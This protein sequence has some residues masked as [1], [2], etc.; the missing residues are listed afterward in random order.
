MDKKEFITFNN[1]FNRFIL[2]F[3]Q[4]KKNQHKISIDKSITL[5]EVHLI[6]VIGKNQ[7][8]NLVKL[9]ELLKV[10]RSAITQS[11]RRLIQ[12][13]LVVFDFA[14]NN[15]KNKYLR[16]SEK[17]IEVFKIHKEQQA[18][19]EES[20]FSVLN[21]YSEEELQTVVK[22]MDDIENIWGGLPW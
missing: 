16:L 17:G 21:N 12:K 6:V 1:R 7:P 11:V 19:I 22:L 3:E 18:Y 15:G 13:N 5:N 4:L 20:V 2:T 9:S 8:L 10:S 14:P